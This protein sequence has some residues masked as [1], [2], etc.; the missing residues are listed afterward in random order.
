MIVVVVVVVV[1]GPRGAQAAGAATGAGP[2][3]RA[4][5]LQ[6]QRCRRAGCVPGRQWAGL[7][8]R[9]AGGISALS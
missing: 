2:T 9:L 4:P 6:G 7:G 8:G 1:S 5:P 3:A